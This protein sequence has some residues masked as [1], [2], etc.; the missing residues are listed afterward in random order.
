MKEREIARLRKEVENY[1][2]RVDA[3]DGKPS[4]DEEE[5]RIQ[6]RISDKENKRAAMYQEVEKLR[7][8]RKKAEREREEERKRIEMEEEQKKAEMK[9]LKEEQARIKEEEQKRITAEEL[10]KEEEEKRKR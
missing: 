6:A 4:P 2:D 10:R 7:E 9:R 1:Q 3:S 5:E 8:L